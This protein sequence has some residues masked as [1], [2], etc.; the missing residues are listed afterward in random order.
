MRNRLEQSIV[1]RTE[2]QVRLKQVTEQ[3]LNAE[4][5]ATQMDQ[6]MAA[7]EAKQKEV[8]DRLKM[9]RDI[10]FRT[11]EKLHNAKIEEKNV[12]AAIEG[13]KAAIKNLRSRV[14]KMDHEVLKQQEILYMQD[15][16]TQQL[17]RRI[18]RMS[19]ETSNE[20][21]IALEA[22]LA[23]LNEEHGKKVVRKDT[24]TAQLKHLQVSS[25]ERKRNIETWLIIFC[26]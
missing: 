23:E 20:E 25:G 11:T 22:K 18:N 19:G 1:M 7:E 5:L 21:K 4:Q 13:S 10:E 15:F 9:Q 6:L 24:I 14:K 26:Y 2:M 12:A 17:E 3:K 8:E 16:N